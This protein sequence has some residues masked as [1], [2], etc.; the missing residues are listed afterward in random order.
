MR[1][2]HWINLLAVVLMATSGW[3]IYNAAPF[4]NFRVPGAITLG[5]WLGGALQWH[6]AGMWL[7]VL[8]GLIYLALN[9]SSG[10]LARK[11]FPLTLAVIRHDL[12]DA[13]RGQLSHADP[14]R[15]NGLQRA[16]Y[17]FAIAD[18]ALLVLSGLVLWKSVQIPFLTEATGGYEAA[19]RVHFI[20]MAAL[21]AFVA[22]HLVMVA[23]VPR[24]LVAMIRGR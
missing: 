22:G 23:L 17:L 14:R 24:T 4:F 18:L 2:S 21:M 16:A 11:F 10:R 19:R 5:G 7:L 1:A 6:F 13:L 8:N 20:A 3:R 9:V 12:R 15:Y